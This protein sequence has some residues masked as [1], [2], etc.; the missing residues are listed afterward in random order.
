MQIHNAIFGKQHAGELCDRLTHSVLPEFRIAWTELPFPQETS[1]A[2]LIKSTALPKK[3]KHLIYLAANAKRWCPRRPAE[4]CS[5]RLMSSLSCWCYGRADGCLAQV[6]MQGA[7]A[8]QSYVQ[9]RTW[10]VQIRR[11]KGFLSGNREDLQQANRN[12][13]SQE[14]ISNANFRL[15]LKR[16]H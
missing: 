16:C 12:S 3:S 9:T 15:H 8:K 7:Q 13:T 4:L 10:L 14:Y 5:S 1:L 2:D 11:K 6:G